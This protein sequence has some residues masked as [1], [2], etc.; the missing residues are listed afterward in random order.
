MRNNIIQLR[1][2]SAVHELKECSVKTYTIISASSREKR[3]ET[4]DSE[5]YL[6][7]GGQSTDLMIAL[8]WTSYYRCLTNG[9]LAKA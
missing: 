6:P 1:N 2:N 5:L 7:G 3:E 8:V 4:V 9:F